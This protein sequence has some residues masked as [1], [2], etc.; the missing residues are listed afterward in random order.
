MPAIDTSDGSKQWH[1]AWFSL[2][3]EQRAAIET[4]LE[5]AQ[6]LA[7]ISERLNVKDKSQ[8]PAFRQLRNNSG[9][10]QNVVCTTYGLDRPQSPKWV[11][12]PAPPNKPASTPPPRPPHLPPTPPHSPLPLY[13]AF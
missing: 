6:S 4:Y 9:F 11:G 12:V 5:T 1:Q 10:S 2:T 7:S 3:A 13:R 8:A